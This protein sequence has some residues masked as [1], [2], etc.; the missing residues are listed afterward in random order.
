MYGHDL[1]R[2]KANQQSPQ[3]LLVCK[4]KNNTSAGNGQSEAE[5]IL[6][7]LPSCKAQESK[8]CFFMG[9]QYEEGVG[10]RQDARK[11]KEYYG[12]ACDLGY[13]DGCDEYKR[14]NH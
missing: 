9:V 2:E 13:Q 1:S 11:A 8:G 5:A 14:L 3:A 12:K 10:L 4:Y 7:L 6:N